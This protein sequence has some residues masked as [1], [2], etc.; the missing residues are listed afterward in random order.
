MVY[1]RD[2]VKMEMGNM[3]EYWK[4]ITTNVKDGKE[5]HAFNLFNL[6]SYSQKI[7][8]LLEIPDEDRRFWKKILKK[9]R[10]DVY[11]ENRI[12]IIDDNSDNI[13]WIL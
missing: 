3:R 12:N 9:G 8:A 13:V 6:M 2:L 1:K 11:V 7:F 10:G 4:A 5:A